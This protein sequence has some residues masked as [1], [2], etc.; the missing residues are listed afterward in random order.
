MRPREV[1][2]RAQSEHFTWVDYYVEGDKEVPFDAEKEEGQDVKLVMLPPLS[3]DDLRVFEQKLS[4]PLPGDVLNLLRL[5]SGFDIMTDNVSFTAWGP[6]GYDFLLPH[7]IV[8][9]SDG[10]GNSWVIEVNTETGDWRHVWFVCHDPP[11]LV[12]QCETL[13]EFIDAVLDEYRY[14][15]CVAGHRSILYH[16]DDLCHKVWRNRRKLPTALKLRES[17]DRV[18]REFAQGLDSRAYVADLRSP[19]IGDGFDWSPLNDGPRPVKRLGS[20]LLFG[21][22]PKKGLLSRLFCR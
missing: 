22:E 11:V 15:K 4:G 20:E 16:I 12:Y 17:E 19:A 9:N 18:L 8:L 2:E 10:R 14:E 1:L 21:I 13:S 3:E 7:V 6:W 5:A